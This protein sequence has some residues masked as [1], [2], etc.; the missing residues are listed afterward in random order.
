VKLSPLDVAWL[1][2][3]I[4]LS[5]PL[6]LAALGELVAERTGMLNIGIE[7]M[8]LAGSL[9]AVAGAAVTGS[10]VLGTIIGGCCGLAL[11]AI[12]AALTIQ[13][14]ADQVIIGVGLVLFGRGV[15]DFAFREWLRERSIDAGPIK[16][17]AI[18]GLSELP[19][20]GSALFKQN[21]IVYFAYLLVPAV[22]FV[23][24]RTSWGLV[25]RGAGEKPK[26]L[27]ACGISV[28]A[29]RWVGMATVGF[30]AGVAGAYLSIGQLGSFNEGMSAGK[31]Y[32][33]LA[34]V[35][36]GGYRPLAVVGA[37]LLFGGV[38]ALQLRLQ[39]VAGV[40]ASV[41][42][43]LLA[44]FVAGVAAIA[45]KSW[46]SARRPTVLAA[47][48]GGGAVVAGVLVALVI[49]TPAV[50]LPTQLWIGMPYIAALAVLAGLGT[51]SN[52]PKA[53]TVPYD[54]LAH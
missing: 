20:V 6:I 48:A 21:F 53:L 4:R 41:W 7:G 26:A 18:P 49:T 38:D 9:G 39:P 44:G 25:I 8:M 16:A 45:V 36:F 11:A 12:A 46:R 50:S 27:D 37:C 15:T 34:A 14:R 5:T 29:V 51:S 42:L 17:F 3:T 52:A 33:A 2:A 54:R 47:Q 28:P 19:V 35:I 22:W 43:V 23:L 31:G 40:P 1:A 30:L 10:L 24:Y 32:I 13:L